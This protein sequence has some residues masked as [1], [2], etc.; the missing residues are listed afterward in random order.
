M[1]R[2]TGKASAICII[3]ARQTKA[4]DPVE[5]VVPWACCWGIFCFGFLWTLRSN[6][7]FFST[8]VT[9]NLTSTF[10]SGKGSGMLLLFVLLVFVVRM[11]RMMVSPLVAATIM[12]CRMNSMTSCNAERG[13]V[14]SSLF[15][16]LE[17]F[18]FNF[19]NGVQVGKL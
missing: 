2:H 4:L 19:L 16:N 6:V 18:L 17:K 3:H 5:A 13:C 12:I 10:S 11:M 7:A 8:V 9:F 1:I 15:I 14:S